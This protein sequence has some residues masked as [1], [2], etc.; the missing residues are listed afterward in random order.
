MSSS[1]KDIYMYLLI[2]YLLSTKEHLRQNIALL[3]FERKTIKINDFCT[4]LNQRDFNF[5]LFIHSG[6]AIMTT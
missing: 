3:G 1:E 5:N 2:F 6:H 4:G